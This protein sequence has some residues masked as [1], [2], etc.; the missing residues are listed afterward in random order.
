MECDILQAHRSE[1]EIYAVN[2]KSATVNLIGGFTRNKVFA[3][4]SLVS[5]TLFVTA[6]LLHIIHHLLN[7][8]VSVQSFG[9]NQFAVH[10]TT[11]G[12]GLTN[13]NRVNIVK[14]E[15]AILDELCDTSLHLCP[16]HFIVN[17]RAGNGNVQRLRYVACSVLLGEPR[18]SITLT[19][20]VCHIANY[21]PL[22]FN[23]AVPPLDSFINVSLREYTLCG[24]SLDR[25]FNCRNWSLVLGFCNAYRLVSYFLGDFLIR[26]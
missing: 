22:A 3:C 14:T 13:G 2:D 18:R 10:N 7:E 12:K 25:S 15:P 16:G 9:V 23:I 20:V 5:D 17:V 24:R 26:T 11:L 6:Y 1:V 8:R 4:E 21:S 19:G